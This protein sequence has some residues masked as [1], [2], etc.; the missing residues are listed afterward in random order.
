MPLYVDP[1]AV[2]C[3]RF[4]CTD[5]D[6]LSD[7]ARGLGLR[8]HALILVPV[9]DNEGFD[10]GSG[11][12]FVLPHLSPADREGPNKAFADLQTV[13][14]KFSNALVHG[15]TRGRVVL[16]PGVICATANHV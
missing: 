4:Q 14:M 12:E 5:A 9:N 3:A 13:P 2:A 15:D 11:W 16:S 7:L 6:E 10:C 1:A 8:E